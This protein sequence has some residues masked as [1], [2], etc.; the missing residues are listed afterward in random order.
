MELFSHERVPGLSYSR[1]VY[2]YA[3]PGLIDDHLSPKSADLYVAPLP[4]GWEP[5]ARMG[6]A[7]ATF[8]P[9]EQMLL[10][11]GATSF[12]SAPIWQ[13]GRLLLWHPRS[14]G[15]RIGLRFQVPASGKYR[16]HLVAGLGPGSGLVHARLKVGGNTG[17]EPEAID[18]Y[19]PFRTLSRDFT[20][21]EGALTSGP[22]EV[23]LEF[24]KN[25]PDVEK[26][27][28]GLDFLWI[29]PVRN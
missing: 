5:A 25:G 29:Q 7:G 11:G 8:F 26:A 12:L 16:V 23:E 20:V 22:H 4:D 13:G 9:A 1:I 21:Y 24:L 19:R 15:E 14:S 3:R 18:L 17:K 28:I 27:A 2:H 10:S 6:A